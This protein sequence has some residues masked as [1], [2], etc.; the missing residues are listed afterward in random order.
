[1]HH[2]GWCAL[3]LALGQPC[4]R[5]GDPSSGGQSQIQIAVLEAGDDRTRCERLSGADGDANRARE[6]TPVFDRPGMAVAPCA[7]V[8]QDFRVGPLIVRCNAPP[9]TDGAA[10][11]TGEVSSLALVTLFLRDAGNIVSP[12]HFCRNDAIR[13]R[14]LVAS[15]VKFAIGLQLP[16]FP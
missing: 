4:L 9:R 15:A 7:N 12:K 3:E 6:L 2:V 14:R 16:L 5:I 8:C 13:L 10:E 11:A 1:E